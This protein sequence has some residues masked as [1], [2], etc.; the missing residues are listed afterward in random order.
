MAPADAL[1]SDTADAEAPDP[2]RAPEPAASR[3]GT[4]FVVATPIGNLGDLTLRAIETLRL[5][6]RVVAEDTRRT[7]GLL[8]HLG[9]AGKP[10]DRLDAHADA[11][12]IARIVDCLIAGERVAVVTDAGTPVVS[13]PGSALV[14]AAVAAGV[15]VVPIPGACAAVA[16]LSAAGL[17][18]VGPS[19]FRFIGFLPR[20]GPERRAAM[21]LIEATPEPVVLYESPQRIADTLSDLAR[22]MPSRSAVVARE[23]T[24]MHEE[25]VRGRL[26]DVAEAAA[27][28]E[29]LGEI[30]LVLGPRPEEAAVALSDEDLA[31][32]IDEGLRLGRRAKDLA[33]ELSLETGLPRRELYARIVERRR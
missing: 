20:S 15:S 27:K 32:R 1:D 31:G 29:W 13:D 12:H 26:S 5:V 22:V 17:P 24:K 9:I 10:I 33:E 23:L 2:A 7:R 3:P 4:L 28:R 25:F 14:C 6:H 21:V 18:P 30:S 19:G 11:Q 8:S 16:A